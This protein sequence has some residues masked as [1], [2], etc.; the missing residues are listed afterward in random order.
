MR[1][2][3]ERYVRLYTRDTTTWLLLPW[4]GRALLPLILR[5]VD[6]AGIMDLGE[7]G[8]EALAA[9]V[10]LPIDVVEVGLEA[11][12]RRGVLVLRQDGLLVWPRFIEAQEARQSDRAR[13]RAARERARDMASAIERGVTDRDSDECDGSVTK[14][15]GT[16]TKR[17][18][19]VQRSATASPRDKTVVDVAVT[20]RDGS[21][22]KRD[23]QNAHDENSVV[24]QNVTQRDAT[25]TKRD[26]AVTARDE[27]VTSR[28]T[29]SHGVTPSCA[30]LNCAVLNPPVN[31]PPQ[32]GYGGGETIAGEPTPAKRRRAKP[33]TARSLVPEDWTPSERTLAVLAAEGVAEDVALACVPEF[34]DYW[35]GTGKLMANW[36]ATFRNRV[37][38]LKAA[39][40]LPEPA[41]RA[42]H[43]TPAVPPPRPGDEGPPLALDDPRL[44]ELRARVDALAARQRPAW[45]YGDAEGGA[46]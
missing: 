32:G 46:T 8:T 4:Q 39:C 41:R 17:D 26:D 13:A 31:T 18:E 37:R 35:R 45:L 27:T 29:A 6:R 20:K 7:D 36:D 28:H 1:Y 11:L 42:G 2:E 40:R 9:H 25:V 5:K 24:D 38:A 12:L 21:V 10:G 43:D 16:V 14:R 34:V 44:R 3:D 22:T 19:S 15:D 23:K 33:S 30:V